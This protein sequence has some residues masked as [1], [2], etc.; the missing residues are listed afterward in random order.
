LRRLSLLGLSFLLHAG[1][2]LAVAKKVSTIKF[3]EPSFDFGEVF[4]GDQLSH[5]FRFVNIGDGALQVQGVHAACGCTAVEVD[6]GKSYEPGE[7]GFVD[8]KLDTADFGGALVKTVTVMTNERVMP[9]RTLTLKAFVKS[10]VDVVPPLADFGDVAPGA[11]AVQTI[12]LKPIGGAKIDVSGLSFNEQLL[13]V[14]SEK[15]GDGYNLTVTLKKDLPP[16]FLKEL[17][18]VKNNTNHLKELPIPVRATVKGAL[19]TTPSYLEF[20]AIDPSGKAKREVLLSGAKGVDIASTRTELMVNGRKVDD[21]DKMLRVT[22]AATGGDKRQV[23]IEITNPARVPG[24]VHGKLFIKTTDPGQP[25]V[26]VDLY[27]F[28]R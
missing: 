14:K 12:A 16:G 8:I 2:A 26:A 5:R 28:F 10:E 4:R 13:D 6:R 7:S 17:I 25:E 22:P 11:P 9:D 1:S 27:A 23:A 24:A 15:A 21:A 19:E 20:G 18:V 3:D